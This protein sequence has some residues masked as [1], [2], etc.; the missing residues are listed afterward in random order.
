MGGNH[1]FRTVVVDSITEIQRVCRKNLTGIEQMQIQDWGR[2][3]TLM[4][5]VIRSYRNFIDMPG[6]P[7]KCAVFVAETRENGGKL[8]PYMQG[9]ISVSLPYF[10]DICAFLRVVA[11]PDENGQATRPVRQLIVGPVDGYETG[12]RVQGVLPAII[13]NPDITKIMRKITKEVNLT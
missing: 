4:D 8:R 6:N 7:I 3:L 5:D 13:A 1:D 11:T 10:V 2:L 12:E 9:Q